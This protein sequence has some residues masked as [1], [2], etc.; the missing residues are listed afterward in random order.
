MRLLP[1]RVCFGQNRPGLAKTKVQL[2]E[3]TLALPH[4]Q[5]DPVF[6]VHPRRQGLAIPQVHPHSGVARFAAEYPI[7]LFD[8]FLVKTGRTP[9]A[10]S[11]L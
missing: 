5:T 6:L 3:Q 8:L 9:G 11:L 10:L 4:A 7:D 2:P 1:C